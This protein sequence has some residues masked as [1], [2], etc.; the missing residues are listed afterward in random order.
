[1]KVLSLTTS[2]SP[3]YKGITRAVNGIEINEYFVS[4]TT[5]ES[6]KDLAFA[7]TSLN[8]EMTWQGFSNKHWI[9]EEKRRIENYIHPLLQDDSNLEFLDFDEISFSK[10]NYIKV[11]E[12]IKISDSK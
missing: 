1:M 5:E 9:D 8:N 7:W 12:E 6:L 10:E 4:I 11:L 2:K 3:Y